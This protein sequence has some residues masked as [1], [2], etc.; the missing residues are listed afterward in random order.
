MSHPLDFARPLLNAAGMLGFAPDPKGPAPLDQLG[1]FFTN[2]ISRTPRQPASGTRMIETPGS[3][4]LHT[5]HPNPGFSAALKKYAK[6]WV[7]APLPVVVH[8]LANSPDDLRYMIEKLEEIENI[9]VVEVG[10]PPEINAQESLA[11]CRAAL[12][13]LPFIVRVSVDRVV[14]LAQAC[15]VAGA[16]AV[17]LGPRRDALPDP[18]G[19]LVSGRVY[20]PI[21]FP[22]ALQTV[23][24]IVAMDIPVIGAGGVYNSGQTQAM[25]DA[26]ALAVQLDTVL[27][28]C[29]Y[30]N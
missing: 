28:R 3:V 19:E 10:L 7:N 25:L 23:K 30:F 15:I 8:L 6:R 9:L 21:H 11:F 16:A 5:G 1:A 24:E 26:G 20:G 14:E 29:G 2:P 13:E 17:S 4:L 22:Q 27:W 12:G 18:D